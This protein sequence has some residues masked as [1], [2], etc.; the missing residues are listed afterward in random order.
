M[1]NPFDDPAVREKIARK[2][3]DDPSLAYD[4]GVGE[5]RVRE[6][7]ATG[8]VEYVETVSVD[9]ETE[10]HVRIRQAHSTVDF[11]TGV[12][13]RLPDDLV[14]ELKRAQGAGLKVTV[15]Y[16]PTENL[17]MTVTRV[18]VWCERCDCETDAGR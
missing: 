9:G 8:C 10:T 13:G 2:L 5:K 16:T 15:T 18:R 7:R 17:T 3:N 11:N 4:V 1:D 12:N 6:R 14:A